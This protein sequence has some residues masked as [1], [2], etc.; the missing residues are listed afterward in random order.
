MRWSLGEKVVMHGKKPGGGQKSKAGCQKHRPKK[1]MPVPCQR[2]NTPLSQTATTQGCTTQ[3]ETNRKREACGHGE[4][5]GILKGPT[6]LDA[7]HRPRHSRGQIVSQGRPNYLKEIA[8]PVIVDRESLSGERQQSAETCL[9]RVFPFTEMDKRGAGSG[10][11]KSLG[12]SG[13]ARAHVFSSVA[14]PQKS[15]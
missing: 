3:C 8:T 6:T 12:L 7:L 5:P 2:K 1:L 13:V 15:I 10:A 9:G 4:M 11:S 14:V